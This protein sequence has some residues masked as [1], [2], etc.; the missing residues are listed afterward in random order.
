MRYSLLIIKK[1]PYIATL[2][3]IK[4][5]SKLPDNIRPYVDFK[6]QLEDRR[7][8]GNE[9][10]AIFNIVTTTAYVPVFLDKDKTLED[11]IE[12]VKRDGSASVNPESVERLRR[13]LR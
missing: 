6:A 8:E 3:D 10:V 12:E 13:F 4:K 11:I 2:V 9:K 1:M 7:L 5:V